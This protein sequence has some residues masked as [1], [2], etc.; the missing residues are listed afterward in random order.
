MEKINNNELVGKHFKV[1][2][3]RELLNSWLPHLKQVPGME[4]I[5]LEGSLVDPNRENPGSDIDIHFAI[6]DDVY[7]EVWES[8]REQVFLP[9]GEVLLLS[10]FR[11]ITEH[12]IL[13]EFDGHKTSDVI[14]KEVFKQEFLLN[15]LPEGQPN[16]HYREDWGRASVKWPYSDKIAV[17][18]FAEL[19]TLELL[20]RLSTAAT[21]FYKDEPFSA[22]MCLDLLRSNLVHILY[23]R[24]GVK[25]FMR[26]KHLDQ[27]FC[28]DML[29]QYE[30][31]QFRQ[32]EN[33]LEFSSIA[34]AT[35]RTFEMLI[36]NA[37]ALH[38]QAGLQAPDKWLDL[39]DRKITTQL[40]EFC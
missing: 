39:L 17:E 27:V 9:L 28:S 34:K 1:E 38:E 31:V 21:P 32:D 11:V 33:P 26:T 23:Y 20:R 14:G 40:Q 13:V 2:R 35:L 37:R 29:K 6:A 3:Q 15:R 22:L 24:K 7:E 5:W 4:L 36:K 25:P 8:N 16:F 19:S 12:G 30:Y 10:P 18:K